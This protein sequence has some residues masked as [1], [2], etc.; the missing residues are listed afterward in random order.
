MEERYWS[1]QAARQ[2]AA[3]FGGR[4]VPAS[5]VYDFICIFDLL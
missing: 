2:G 5:E 4:D 1:A 3:P